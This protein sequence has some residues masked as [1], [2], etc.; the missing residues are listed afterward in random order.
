MPVPCPRC[1][2]I[3]CVRAVPLHARLPFPLS[4]GKKFP[5]SVKKTLTAPHSSM[6]AGG[7]RHRPRHGHGRDAPPCS[8]R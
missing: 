4:I 1:R 3:A 8:G 5:W 2:I 6:K 7:T